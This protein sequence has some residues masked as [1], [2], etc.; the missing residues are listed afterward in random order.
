MR[1][2][3]T[4]RIRLPRKKASYAE[5]ADFFDR[6]D[7]TELMKQGIMEPDLDREDLK[8]LAQERAA[9]LEGLKSGPAAKIDKDYWKRKRRELREKLPAAGQRNRDSQNPPRGTRH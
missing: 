2:A 7:G 3:R 5:L 9:V 4:S 8:R 1:K 6:H